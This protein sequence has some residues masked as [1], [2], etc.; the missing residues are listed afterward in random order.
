MSWF[1]ID[2]INQTIK[3]SSYLSPTA[4]YLRNYFKLQE[5]KPNSAACQ[6]E[7]VKRFIE[8]PL[9]TEKFDY[10]KSTFASTLKAV[11]II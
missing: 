11:N 10:F 1:S 6:V 5:I 4:Q 9:E 3:V 8:K 2:L 7:I